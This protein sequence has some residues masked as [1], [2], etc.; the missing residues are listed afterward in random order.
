VTPQSAYFTGNTSGLTTVFGLSSSQAKTIG[1]HWVSLGSGTSQYASLKAD[2]TTSSVSDLLPSAKKIKLSRSVSGGI[3]EY[4]LSWT[5]ATTSSTPQISTVLTLSEHGRPLPLEVIAVGTDHIK[6]T[7][8]LSKWG[9][10]V[11]VDAPPARSTIAF[12]KVSS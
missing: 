8:K 3:E 10:Q 7:V 4:V 2:T 5:T 6:E 12:S 1:R 11:V 9:E